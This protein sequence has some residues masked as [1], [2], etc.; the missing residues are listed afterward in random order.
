[1]IDIVKVLPFKVLNFGGGRGFENGVLV[2]DCPACGD[3]KGRGYI[4]VSS[5]RAGCFRAS[6]DLGSGKPMKEW[7][8]ALITKGILTRQ[9][10]ANIMT[11][12]FGTPTM[13][14]LR[15]RQLELPNK[16][17]YIR[18]NGSIRPLREDDLPSTWSRVK[19]EWLQRFGFCWADL[20]FGRGVLIPVTYRFLPCFYTVRLSEGGYMA[21]SRAESSHSKGECL[22]GHDFLPRNLDQLAI[23][24]SAQDAVMLMESERIPAVALLG[25]AMT[26]IQRSMIVRL[27]PRTVIVALDADAEGQSAMLANELIRFLPIV[28][29]GTWVGA[30]DAAS[31]GTLKIL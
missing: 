22:F 19:L 23:V 30:K 2:F 27:K 28:R 4:S 20:A 29:I 13:L 6:C 9:M 3:R 15:E 21:A 10:A 11:A 17:P 25:S 31:G 7:L 1:M 18:I 12:I 8:D 14:P 16:R 24:E 5:R 26:Q